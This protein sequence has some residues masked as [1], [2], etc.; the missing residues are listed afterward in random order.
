MSR[1]AFTL[2]ELL[3]VIAIIA[4]L[5]AMLLPAL[6]NAKARAIQIKCVSNLKQVGTAIQMFVDDNKDVL[7]PGPGKDYGLYFGQRAGY[8]NRPSY[9]FQMCY[10]IHDYLGLRDVTGTA[11]NFVS[12]FFCPGIARYTPPTPKV[13]P[14]SDRVSY[15]CYNYHFT[16]NNQYH[17]DF[18]PFGYAAGESSDPPSAP[19]KMS[20]IQAEAPLSEIWSLADIDQVVMGK[21]GWGIALP[22]TPVH[23][24]N[25][26]YLYF[27]T[28]VG[29]Q[30]PGP[31][32]TM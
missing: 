15:G 13:P 32:G 10:Y 3:V 26:N 21:S 29:Q 22:P 24:Q 8:A 30:K 5:A 31:P 16:T 11:T 18:R 20:E 23:G 14:N 7:P 27:D 17:L 6:A 9:S 12:V 4:I 19:H 2:I 25:R 28:H 1:N